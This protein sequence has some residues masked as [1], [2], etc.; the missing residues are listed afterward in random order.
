MKALSHQDRVDSVDICEQNFPNLVDS[1]HDDLA[2]IT[3]QAYTW[4]TCGLFDSNG[5][6]RPVIDCKQSCRLSC[7]DADGLE[8][9]PLSQCI[10]RIAQCSSFAV[11][12]EQV[13]PLFDMNSSSSCDH[14]RYP[15]A[16][17]VEPSGCDDAAVIEAKFSSR[18]VDP[19]DFDV[20]ALGQS[21]IDEMNLHFEGQQT[22]CAVRSHC[23]MSVWTASQSGR[24]MN[25]DSNGN[26][27]SV[28][29]PYF[30]F[31]NS[32]NF[33]GMTSVVEFEPQ[34]SCVGSSH[35]DHTIPCI[36]KIVPAAFSM[37]DALHDR[38]W[39]TTDP[40]P[41]KNRR[42]V[43]FASRVDIH[44][45]C[46]NQAVHFGV[47][48]HIACY[49][50][51]NFWHLHGQ[52][53]TWNEI[54]A[55][56]MRLEVTTNGESDSN[57]LPAQ[58]T[59][60]K[61]SSTQI[62]GENKV[63][64]DDAVLR[65]YQRWWDDL[66]QVWTPEL[67]TWFLSKGRLEVCLEAR[68]IHISHR[69]SF[70]NFLHDCRRTWLDWDDGS[71]LSFHVVHP[72]PL[73]LPSTLAH[74]IIVQ[75]SWQD[76]NV[77]FYHGSLLPVLRRQRAVMYRRGS[78]V[79]Q[80]F[81]AAQHPEVCQNPDFTC[82]LKVVTDGYEDLT[83]AD[84]ILH[85]PTA[86]YVEGNVRSFQHT[87]EHEGYDDSASNG[88]T[89]TAG[90][91][92]MTEPDDV[93][94]MSASPVRNHLALPE[95]LPDLDEI[96]D[97][98]VEEVA[99]VVPI[100]FAAQH[101]EYFQDELRFMLAEGTNN[102][103]SWYAA[104]F[105][106]GLID[107]G[108]RDILFNPA[109]MQGL[110]DS[111][112]R[113][114]SDH[115]EYG[116]LLVYSVHP[117]PIAELGPRTIALIVV[118]V[119]PESQDPEHRCALIVEQAAMPNMVRP[120]PYAAWLPSVSNE[121]E[122][123]VHLD[124]HKHCP[125][126]TLRTCHVRL[127]TIILE[128]DQPYDFANGVLCRPWIGFVPEQVDEA[129]GRIVDVEKFFLQ[130]QSWRSLK[131]NRRQI[132]CHVHGVS[133][134]NR[135]LGHCV[136]V[137]EADWIYDLQWIDHMEQLWPFETR[138]VLLAFVPSATDDF[139][140][141][142][143]ITF[144]FIV[145]YQP[146]ERIP[147]LVCQQLI[148]VD[149]MQRDP[150]G[151][152]EYWAIGVPHTEVGTNIV[153]VMAG[154][155]FWFRYARSQHIHPHMSVNGVKLIEARQ[156]WTTG[157]LL[158]ARFIVWQRHHILYMLTGAAHEGEDIEAEH[159]A[160]FQRSIESV[161]RR[162]SADQIFSPELSAFTEICNHLLCASEK[163]INEDASVEVL[164]DFPGA[165]QFEGHSECQEVMNATE[166]N[167]GEKINQPT[168]KVQ[169]ELE[170]A[171]LRSRH[172][173]N[174]DL[175]LEPSRNKQTSSL[176]VD[177]RDNPVLFVLHSSDAVT[178]PSTH[179][180]VCSDH[181]CFVSCGCPPEQQ[182]STDDI[183]S[184]RQQV[185][186]LQSPTWKGLN[187]DF[188]VIPDLHPF[189]RIASSQAPGSGG[190]GNVFH[191]FTDGSSPKGKAAWSF[192][193][194]Y[195]SSNGHQKVFI[196]VGYAAGR[197]K[198]DVGIF[199]STAHD[200]GATALIAVAEYLLS[201]HD[202]AAL[203]VHLH[204]DAMAVGK[205]T[206]GV[207]K[208]I[209]Q[210]MQTSKRQKSARILMQLVQS[211]AKGLSNFHVHAHCGH[212]WNEFVDSVAA[213]AR[214]GWDPP[215]QAELRSGELLNHE[216]VE[217]AWLVLNPTDELPDLEQILR[218]EKPD[219]C[220]GDFDRTLQVDENVVV[221]EA[222]TVCF[223]VATANVGTLDQDFGLMG[224][225]ITHKAQE[226]MHQFDNE[227]IHVVALQETRARFSTTKRHG[228]FVC[229]VSESDR[230]QG[231]VEIWFN[232]KAIQDD[233]AVE[234]D[235]EKDACV[236]HADSRILAVK[237]QFGTLSIEIITCYAPQRGRGRD[238]IVTWWEHFMRVLQK[239]DKGATGPPFLS[240]VT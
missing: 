118:V 2:V 167:L 89:T 54:K 63:I 175:M 184:L 62:E 208:V 120:V 44:V 156:W 170:K 92:D 17:G 7:K 59:V 43:A 136:I 18:N 160:F 85:I 21:W 25:S 56:V 14:F 177:Q 137:I 235:P 96:D 214:D 164:T 154:S 187:T 26:T 98:V 221:H 173:D 231:G 45:F 149:E 227:G 23:N 191:I 213:L 199:T 125:P 220:R 232:C 99:A 5:E 161:Q 110:M 144:H 138:D 150:S 176:Q 81:L 205:G 27:A 139:N 239:A 211:K 179:T 87:Y 106:L 117:Q 66:L 35:D 12:S 11:D 32:I 8:S 230:G 40:C 209:Q 33:C 158:R 24:G 133:P 76:E 1:W 207:T 236:W 28:D 105:G 77:A 132:I 152:N 128:K 68:R 94:L 102:E 228:H 88:S 200:A 129:A 188:A 197:L 206:C 157:D 31:P 166:E 182:A 203:T 142:N 181:S 238:E 13:V 178:P 212:P 39:H 145:A 122:I 83:H 165:D 19:F 78:T 115:A 34:V 222:K 22:W 69:Q 42:S 172:E 112:L 116:D 53:T 223:K 194:L 189:A 9:L 124:L 210:D 201:R 198:D 49:W 163:A 196:R 174:T 71:D 226:L 101:L 36:D 46:G 237:C 171:L 70:Q 119:M 215:I 186:N 61:S 121:A 190:P 155:P 169:L 84:E 52:T 180:E 146:Q 218:N 80:F 147:I 141:L 114:W 51:R 74:V 217:W 113:V 91:A 108:R 64:G 97:Q 162:S 192:V 30:G 72:K 100:A 224:S 73:G 148:A 168:P 86:A 16:C 65:N 10:S 79:K 103:G 233:F 82:Y 50:L 229:L 131:G 140:E 6:G 151:V 153:N 204:F 111:I 109:D 185:Q 60:G 219:E 4:S 3:G 38:G 15:A 135:P 159:K 47:D 75:G 67:N 90:S 193:V 48:E 126:F 58:I 20:S 104:T 134:A 41:Q 130:T 143:E 216:L 95:H 37:P 123:L 202:L 195:E 93:G 57:P 234:F 225:S 55:Q 240:W 183:A 107:L 127:G 29:C